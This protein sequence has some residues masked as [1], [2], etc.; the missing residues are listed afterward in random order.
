MPSE[1]I[2]NVKR[3]QIN[4]LKVEKTLKI[5]RF[6]YKLRVVQSDPKMAYFVDKIVISF[7][8]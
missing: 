1:I 7:H 8:D 3:G 5:C 4:R 2:E 6:S